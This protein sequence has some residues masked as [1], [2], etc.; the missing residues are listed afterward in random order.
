MAD[1]TVD[2]L[3]VGAGAG[4][5]TAA[6]VCA[7]QGLDVLLCEKSEQVGGTTA[8][9]AGTIW[10]PGTRQAREAGMPDTIAEARRYLD[11][12]IGVADDR[13]EIYLNTAAEVVDYLDRNSEVKFSIYRSIRTTSPTGPARPS[14]GGRW[15]RCRSTG[16]CSAPT[17][18]RYVR[19]SVSS[20]R[21]AA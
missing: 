10:V 20:W 13:R 11:A 19:R 5:M 4:G 7:L 18:P 14:P 2:V 1:T 9:S 6:L 15:R 12:I 8:T 3:V 17:S 21:S 16:G